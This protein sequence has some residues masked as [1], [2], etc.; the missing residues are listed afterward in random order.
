MDIAIPHPS[1]N[2]QQ[3]SVRTAGFFSPAKLFLNGT[4]VQPDKG[5]YLVRDDSGAET[6][7]TLKGNFI[8]PIPVVMIGDEAVHLARP[9]TWYE[10]AWIGLPLAMMFIGGAL[11]GALG[12]GAAFA[13]SHVFRGERGPLAKYALTGLISL[14]AFAAYVM[15]VVMLRG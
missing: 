12:F 14:G 13:S 15:I 6:V 7:I 10:Y 1:F 5:K 9:L 11:G 3:I 8:D 2:T 4:P